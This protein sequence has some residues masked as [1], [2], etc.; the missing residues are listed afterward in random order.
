MNWVVKKA[1][2]LAILLAASAG[3]ASAA[4]RVEAG[5]LAGTRTINSTAIKDVYGTGMIIYPYAAIH[6]WKGL[7]VGL[8]YEGGAAR[9]GK[10]GLYEEPTTLKV[11]GFE[12]FAGYEIAVG[13][14]TPYIKAGYASYSYKQVIDS[15]YLSVLKLKTESSKGT[16]ALGG[17]LKVFMS[18]TFFLAGEFRFVPLMVKPLGTEVDLGGLRYTAGI[19]VRF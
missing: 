4:V 19:G 12:V 13:M 8:G 11:T 9:S 3:P 1:A 2:V 15:P 17:G 18:G 7:F 10:I 6:P 14:V 5:V 16:V